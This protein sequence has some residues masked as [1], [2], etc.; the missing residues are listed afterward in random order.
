MDYRTVWNVILNNVLALTILIIIL[1]SIV[2]AFIRQRSRDR[3]LHDFENYFVTL[4]MK[5]GRTINGKLKLYSSGMELKFKEPLNNKYSY[6]VSYAELERDMQALH[7]YHWDLTPKN[8]KQREKSIKKT[9]RPNIIRRTRRS[10]RNIVNTLRD[11][12]NK[13]L[14]LFIGSMGNRIAGGRATQDMTSVGTS[15]VDMFVNAYDSVL[16]KYIGR[17]IVVQIEENGKFNEYE[18]VLKEYTAKYM[19]LLNVKYDF[20][21]DR[22]KNT[23]KRDLKKPVYI[24]IIAPRSVMKIRYGGKPERLSLRDMFGLS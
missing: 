9:Y 20:T 16:E 5:N 14:T 15:L 10:L 11:A 23:L 2:S 21:G 1:T 22:G 24:D 8:M 19:E 6:I 3:C 4:I 18:G 12:F 13:S 17:K 7:R